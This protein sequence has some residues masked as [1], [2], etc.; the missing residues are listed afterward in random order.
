MNAFAQLTALHS[1]A[2]VC[3]L[4]VICHMCLQVVVGATQHGAPVGRVQRQPTE[5]RV[6]IRVPDRIGPWQSVESNRKQPHRPAPKRSHTS[7]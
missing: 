5:Y 7:R 1:T 3:M 6:H 2:Y 4:G